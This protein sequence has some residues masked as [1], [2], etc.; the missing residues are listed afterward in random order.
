MR[1]LALGMGPARVVLRIHVGPY[2]RFVRGSPQHLTRA[3][4]RAFAFPL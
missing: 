2:K 3:E 1:G 4:T